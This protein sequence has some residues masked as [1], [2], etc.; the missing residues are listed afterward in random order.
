LDFLRRQIIA[1]H[2]VELGVRHFQEIIVPF[3]IFRPEV[4]GISPVF[5]GDGSMPIVMTSTTAME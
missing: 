2:I 1:K 4:K 5:I 3:G